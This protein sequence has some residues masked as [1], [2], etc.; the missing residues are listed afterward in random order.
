MI[1]RTE[2]KYHPFKTEMSKIS[3]STRYWISKSDVDFIQE[4][5]FKE[6]IAFVE[7]SYD[8]MIEATQ[9]IYKSI[10]SEIISKINS[11]SLFQLI[12]QETD[13]N[14]DIITIFELRTNAVML[15]KK[16]VISR[17]KQGKYEF[18]LLLEI[19]EEIDKATGEYY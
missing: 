11:Q 12:D 10:A 17:L 14:L 3:D 16:K 7:L 1:N 2:Q 13:T 19:L 8:E 4:R 15:T 18:K 5:S 9:M 6:R